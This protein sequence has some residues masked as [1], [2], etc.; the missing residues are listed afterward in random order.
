MDGKLAGKSDKFYIT[1]PIFYVN[2]VPHLGHSYTMVVSDII[3]RWH[4]LLGE[5]VFFL[6]GTDEHGEKIAKAAELRKEEVKAFVDKLAEAYKACWKGLSISNDD[7]IR[8][9][10]RRHEEVVFRFIEAMD[11]NGD[12]YKGEY[13]G[14]YCVPDETFFTDLQLKEGRCPVCG[15]DVQKLKEESYF[16]RLSKYQDRLLEYYK[17]NENFLA[18]KSRSAE[19]INRVK[20][21]LKDLSITRKSVKWGI[22]F[23]MDRKH[24]IYVW[25]EALI[26]YLSALDWRSE[27]SDLFWPADVHMVGKEINWF[28]SVIWPAMLFSAGLEP[29]RKVFAHGWWTVEGQKM[30]KSVGN[31][32]DPMAMAGKYSVDAL[33]Y[34]LVREIPL[35][36]DG[37]FSEKA[38][39]LRLNNELAADLGNLAYRV[40]SITEKFD[41]KIEGSPELEAS[42]DLKGIEKDMQEL[43]LSGALERIWH[44][45]KACNKYVNDKKP[46]EMDGAE[47]SNA[48]Y[49]LLESLR[50]IS[51]LV[52]PFMPE[53]S[54]RLNAQLGVKSGLLSEAKFGAFKG[55]VKK[56]EYLF[57]KID[58]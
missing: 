14:W 9:T 26:N 24:N 3:A 54:D 27:K 2:D 58:A 49:N 41:G 28:H 35:G 40:L 43:N 57:R 16:F 11:R 48:L 36:D 22:P 47:L 5:R 44:F 10:E 13:E 42:L 17:A 21:G 7:F 34:F 53:T 38:L 20:G 32:V 1:T 8:T 51:I 52:S 37:D 15:R 55:K 4:R 18:P 31:V 29:P 50:I 6:T 19:I 33:R 46:W 39:R 56:G 25:V 23:P 45:I 12:L 30:S